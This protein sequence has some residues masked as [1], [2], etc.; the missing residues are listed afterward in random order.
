MKKFNQVFKRV[1]AVLIVFALFVSFNVKADELENATGL[2]DNLATETEEKEREVE[3][4]PPAESTGETSSVDESQ[5]QSTAENVGET[6][7]VLPEA[8]EPTDANEED[9]SE[10]TTQEVTPPNSVT[11]ETVPPTNDGTDIDVTNEPTIVDETNGTANVETDPVVETGTVTNEPTPV[12][13]P[14]V[15]ETSNNE[16]DPLPSNT[17]EVLPTEESNEEPYKVY[18]TYSGYSVNIIGE[19]TVLVSNLL[20]TLNINIDLENIENVVFENNELI[21]ITKMINGD[22][23]IESLSPFDT[24]EKLYIYTKDGI[25]YQIDVTDPPV[26]PEHHKELTPNTEVIDNGDGTTTVENDGTYN[27]SLTVTGDADPTQEVSGSVNVLIVYDSSSS[28]WHGYAVSETGSYGH[29]DPFPDYNAYQGYVNL[30]SKNEDGTYTQLTLGSTY[31]GVVYTRSGNTY[32][33]YLPWRTYNR[34]NYGRDNAPTDN[35]SSDGYFDLYELLEDGTYERI[36][37]GDDASTVYRYDGTTYTQYTGTRYANY[38]RYS[39]TRAAAAEKAIREFV[40]SLTAYNQTPTAKNVEISFVTFSNYQ[41][42]NTY[43][44]QSW[45]NNKE[46]QIS[47][48]LSD[49]LGS[50]T[51]TY[52]T[53][54]NYEKALQ[55]ALGAG[56]LASADADQTFVIFMTDGQPS[57]SISQYTEDG[58][59]QTTINPYGNDHDGRYALYLQVLDEI[60]QV[61]NYNTGAHNSTTTPSNTTLYGIYAFGKEDDFLDDLI[62]YGTRITNSNFKNI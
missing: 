58:I 23:A 14:S 37:A 45:T 22:W 5:Y 34:G 29:T 42:S 53:G 52:G 38:M 57:Q 27:L 6:V 56:A 12:V 11:D 50:Y 49:D 26:A 47:N 61:A 15:D 43:V 33:E 2:T 40:D 59:S 17:E 51:L 41:D 1:F 48:H 32:T 8:N 31:T 54:T 19:E 44:L 3:L 25:E 13:E 55:V 4:A 20:R 46:G 10:P 39:S 24:S 21:K 60:Q 30:Y 9:K 35:Y 7:D 16:V 36:Q 62:Y 28:M 18:F